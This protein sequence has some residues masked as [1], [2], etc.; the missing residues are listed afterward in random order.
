M[1]AAKES[2]SLALG[3]GG[4]LPAVASEQQ[5]V[6]VATSPRGESPRAIVTSAAAAAGFT[7]GNVDDPEIELIHSGESDDAFKST[8]APPAF[9]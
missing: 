7:T 5:A 3:A 9:G 6:P 1:R 4:N 2:S 8:E